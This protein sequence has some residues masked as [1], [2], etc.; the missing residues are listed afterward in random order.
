[1]DNN[2]SNDDDFI[3]LRNHKCPGVS[4]NLLVSHEDFNLDPESDSVKG[5]LIETSSS[6]R[7]PLCTTICDTSTCDKD[8]PCYLSSSS[9]EL[10]SQLKQGSQIIHDA[11]ENNQMI[12]YSF[13][14]SS[15]LPLHEDNSSN[16][17]AHKIPSIHSSLNLQLEE[18]FD[19]IN[20]VVEVGKPSEISDK[21][22]CHLVR[23]GLI[24]TSS[25]NYPQ[26]MHDLV[27]SSE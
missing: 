27:Q 23:S 22:G 24:E 25:I 7:Y 9:N 26:T 6:S 13:H 19:L 8:T 3:D 4:T 12:K 20:L 10:S 14:P 16:K 21:D 2:H 18:S 5:V 11:N 1:L 15:S 17:L